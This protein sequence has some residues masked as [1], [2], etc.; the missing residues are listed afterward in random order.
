MHII[1]LIFSN[2]LV[3]FLI[4]LSL[5]VFIHELGH[6]LVGRMLGIDVEEFSIGFGPK[7]ISFAYKGT[8]YRLNW[9]PLGGYVR[10]KSFEEEEDLDPELAKKSLSHTNP[11]K[12]VLV[13]IAG[14]VANFLLAIALFAA[15]SYV[16]YPKTEAVISVLSLSPAQ[17]A[18]LHEGDRILTI[19]HKE[20]EDWSSLTKVIGAYTNKEDPLEL[21]YQRGEEIHHLTLTPEFV[22]TETVFGEKKKVAKIGISPFLESPS[23]M[24]AKSSFLYALGLRPFDRLE[25]L[26]GQKVHYLF[27]LKNYLYKVFGTLDATLIARK[28]HTDP[29]FAPQIS[30]NVLRD[31][32][33]LTLETSFHTPLMKEWVEGILKGRE[34][35]IELQGQKDILIL[36]TDLTIR[37]LSKAYKEAS[38][39]SL[40]WE[41]CG[42]K[43]K[44]TLLN[45]DPTSPIL[46]RVDL[47]SYLEKFTKDISSKIPLVH[48]PLSYLTEQGELQKTRCDIELGEKRDHLNRTHKTF[49]FPYEFYTSGGP[50]KSFEYK[51]PNFFKAIQDGVQLGLEQG[52]MIF[53]GI[54]KLIFGQ[55]AL[56]NLG[57]PLS[58]ASIAGDAAKAGLLAFIMT[59]ALI[60]L[61]VGLVNLIPLPG[62][63]GGHIILGLIELVYGK[64]LPLKVTQVIQKVAIL[65]IIT[66]FILVFYNDLL[67]LFGS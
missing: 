34:G 62:L 10:F 26:E 33:L 23:L 19:N 52:L 66:L 41:K 3:A 13:A 27:E 32:H 7:I 54:K 51:S 43:P 38:V 6:F 17:K 22:E 15:I 46:S 5:V 30:L 29:S 20:V 18:G 63:D 49:H 47:S 2:T 9:L 67:R 58:I 53:E 65:I 28:L 1:H 24:V 14:P 36:S 50:M 48:I 31:G 45:L 61:N 21:T 40:A 60:S 44:V 4:L 11:Y 35:F 55:I 56:A 12:K 37:G 42:I 39:D 25:S 64:R 16:G 57:G 8:H 59:T